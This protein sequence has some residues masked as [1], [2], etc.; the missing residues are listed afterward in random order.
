MLIITAADD[1]FISS[2]LFI[3]YFLYFPKKMIKKIR[4]SSAIILLSAFSVNVMKKLENKMTSL[5]TLNLQNMLHKSKDPYQP[6]Y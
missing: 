6:A 3:F 5:S 4:M 2:F 1:I